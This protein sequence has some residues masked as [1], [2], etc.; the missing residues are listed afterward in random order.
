MTT[1]QLSEVPLATLKARRT[2]LVS[3][4]EHECGVLDIIPSKILDYEARLTPPAGVSPDDYLLISTMNA[5]NLAGLKKSQT[6]RAAEVESKS[7]ELLSLM[8]AGMRAGEESMP[9]DVV[10]RMFAACDVDLDEPRRK[11][12]NDLLA[13][14]V[15][16]LLAHEDL[17]PAELVQ[18]TLVA[19]ADPD[20]PDGFQ[21]FQEGKLLHMAARD[22][23]V[24]M[25]AAVLALGEDVDA[26]DGNPEFW[27]Y[28]NTPLFIAA[29][30]GHVDVMRVLIEACAEFA[31]YAWDA[32]INNLKVLKTALHLAARHGQPIAIQVLLDA[33]MVVNDRAFDSNNT[34]LEDA[35]SEGHRNCIAPLLRAGATFD[36]EKLARMRSIALSGG[37]SNGS[38]WRY[39]ERVQEAGGYDQLVLTYRRVL[40]AP[41]SCLVKYLELR[42]GRPAPADLVPSVLEFWKPPGGG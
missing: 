38:A 32:G 39:M 2:S 21:L 31:T 34:P 26:L 17:I 4:L 16:V 40:T 41:R 10:R 20:L 9:A 1:P 36:V 3:E 29:A 24:S 8:M 13:S 33:G 25:A 15:T 12:M 30:K 6:A 18:R 35:L 7:N 23:N 19:E 28:A 5:S 27:R 11:W 42:F 14:M 22:G 37:R